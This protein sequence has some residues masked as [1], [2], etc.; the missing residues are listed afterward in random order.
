LKGFKGLEDDF[1]PDA[2]Q[3]WQA[4][5]IPDSRLRP[6]TAYSQ[7]LYSD[8][9]ENYRARGNRQIPAES[10]DYR[11]NSYGYRGPE[12]DREP[13]ERLVAFLGDSNTLGVGTPWESVWTTVVTGYLAER[14]GV[15]VRQCNLAWGGTGSDYV[16]MMVHQCVD[17]LRP[18]AVFVLWSYVARATWFETARRQR[19]FTPEAPA[20]DAQA[21]EAYLRLAT[22][23]QG[24][25]NYVRNFSLVDQRLANMRV[26]FF[27]GN[28]EGF[29]DQLLASYLPMDGF[30]GRWE[31]LD[32]A[33]DGG[34][35]GRESHAAFAALVIRAIE[36]NGLNW[37]GAPGRPGP[38]PA[39]R[40]AAPTDDRD[41]SG[42]LAALAP[43]ARAM[44]GV[45]AR[46]RVRAMRRHDPFIY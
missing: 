37:G 24:F 33:R 41:R 22:D 4:G 43:L 20:K 18:D 23:A 7:W 19:L 10:V 2:C 17:V 3:Y 46:R 39:R 26:P 6:R 1:A 32:L 21:H 5:R 12:F 14:C 40:P 31:R 8:S 34:H 29:S 27:W 38:R 44:G 36:R 9:A 35:A 45:R 16:A 25:F 42:A 11:F 15:P 13:G 30:A 28:I